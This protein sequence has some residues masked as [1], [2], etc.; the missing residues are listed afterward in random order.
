MYLVNREDLGAGC[1]GRFIGG[2]WAGQAGDQQERTGLW[3]AEW[4]G[5]G[6]AGRSLLWQWLDWCCLGNSRLIGLQLQGW[7]R[8]H[9]QLGWT[10]RNSVLVVY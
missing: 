7:E 3:E 8:L 4:T 6:K 5:L 9:P 2:N 10:G 1:D